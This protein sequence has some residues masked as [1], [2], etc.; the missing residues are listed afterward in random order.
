M[1]IWSRARNA[2]RRV[3]KIAR[4]ELRP[5]AAAEVR[6]QAKKIIAAADKA[7]ESISPVPPAPEPKHKKGHKKAPKA[8]FRT[9]AKS[10]WRR[11]FQA[12]LEMEPEEGEMLSDTVE[13]VNKIALKAMEQAAH[14]MLDRGYPFAAPDYYD[15]S[16]GT[17]YELR[18]GL[19]KDMDLE[20]QFWQIKECFEPP[21]GFYISVGWRLPPTGLTAVDDN[22]IMLEGRGILGAHWQPTSRA[23]E[24]F[25]TAKL[26][27]GGL[28]EGREDGEEGR[29]VVNA[30]LPDEMFIRLAWTKN[31]KAPRSK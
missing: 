15:Y 12:F 30:R 14:L 16:D 24:N 18:V 1:S 21:P 13:G 9:H 10:V 23:D 25:M 31:G 28:L 8:Y 6:K 5:A 29:Y 22:Y 4:E 17:H 2:I 20:A 19:R 11:I 3:A 27:L 7:L 26:N